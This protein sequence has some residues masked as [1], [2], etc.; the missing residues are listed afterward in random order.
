MEMESA[1]ESKQRVLAIHAHPDDTEFMAGGTLAL[2]A[3]K[4]HHI[5]IV[6]M[7]PGD[8]GT[9]E[10]GAEGISAI[11][12]AEAAASAAKI[13]AEYLCAEF[14]DVAVFN[15]D[16]SRRRVVEV[17]RRVRPDVILSAPT[18]DY[19]PDH[20]TAGILVRD[21]V[22]AAPIPNYDTMVNDPA[23]VLNGMPH[24][25]VM[26]PNSNRDRD[27]N[28][29]KPDFVVNVESVYETKKAMLACHES[30]RNWL[31]QHHG[32]DEYLLMMDRWSRECGQMVGFT[33]GEGFRIYKGH[34]YP[35]SPRLEELL[36]ADLVTRLDGR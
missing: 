17:L 26:N 13:G 32:M 36:G 2:L 25:Y 24:L 31:R 33:H 34:P 19:M 35:Q 8:C 27:W 10:Y 1:T 16:S 23:P 12:R 15:D 4:G 11:R 9:A 30:Q 7:T 14:R 22:F 6:T 21:A 29:V 5:T 20:E 3:A 18:V 28:L